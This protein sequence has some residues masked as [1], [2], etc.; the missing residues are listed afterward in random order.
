M[1][2][3]QRNTQAAQATDLALTALVSVGV[4]VLARFKGPYRRGEVD[5]QFELFPPLIAAIVTFCLLYMLTP[6]RGWVG[7][8]LFPIRAGAS[9]PLS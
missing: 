9:P 7:R 2:T 4:G 3:W 5:A 6:K 1:S 8:F